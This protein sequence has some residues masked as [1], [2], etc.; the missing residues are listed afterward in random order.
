VVPGEEQADGIRRVVRQEILDHDEIAQRFANFSPCQ[1]HH[2]GM[3]PP[4]REGLV[5]RA[6]FRLGDFA[7]MMRK[8]EIGA[9][10]VDIDR[11]P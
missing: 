11:L 4:S 3:E 2:R 7:L 5:S 1:L 6:T 8:Q 9:T 10:P